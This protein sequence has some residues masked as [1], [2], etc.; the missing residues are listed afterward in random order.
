MYKHQIH[1]LAEDFLRTHTLYLAVTDEGH[2]HIESE[3]VFN[4]HFELLSFEFVKN[5]F[6]AVLLEKDPADGHKREEQDKIYKV[7]VRLVPYDFTDNADEENK[8]DRKIL[9]F[10]KDIHFSDI[11][12]SK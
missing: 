12:W 4:L 11:V 5:R 10:Y 8:G 7:I 1:E 9:G 2:H 6:F 3:L